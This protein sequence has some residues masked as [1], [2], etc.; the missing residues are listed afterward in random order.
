MQLL[1]MSQAV[2]ACIKEQ[3]APVVAGCDGATGSIMRRS[4][5][6]VGDLGL[7]FG[8]KL[9][10]DLL[11]STEASAS[12]VTTYSAE[13]LENTSVVPCLKKREFCLHLCA[14]LLFIL[15]KKSPGHTSEMQRGHLLPSLMLLPPCTHEVRKV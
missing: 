15:E 10:L 12:R 8:Y 13:D 4:A 2:W 1:T 3:L 9:D 6:L 7:V 5:A 14:D 11:V